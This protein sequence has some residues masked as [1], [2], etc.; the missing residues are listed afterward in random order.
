MKKWTVMLIP[1]DR[2]NTRT[3]TISSLHFWGVVGLLAV[4]TFTT[5]F[6]F[7]RHQV[8][9]SRVSTLREANRALELANSRKPQVV[10]QKGLSEEEARE[11]EQRL[12]AEYESS[13]STVTAQLNELLEIEAKARDITGMAP[14]DT[15]AKGQKNAAATGGKGGPAGPGGSFS[16][17][18]IREMLRPP[19][20]IYGMSRPSADLLLQEIQL[21]KHSLRDLVRDME[22]QADRIERMPSIWPLGRSAGRLISPYGYRRDP[23][24]RRIRLHEGTD[25]STNTGT[26]VRTTAKGVVRAAGYDGD[27]GYM[28][29]I[30]HGNGMSTC[31]A[32][33]SKITTKMGAEVSRGDVIGTVG[34]TGRSTGPH[35]HYEVRVNG[36]PVD[37]EKYLTD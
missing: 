21:R 27:Y 28:V 10:E 25:I 35:L 12:R 11:I 2:G 36:K 30:D 8:I 34:S 29:R 6:F 7:E 14:R 22:V 16:H 15:K 19:N 13:I 3:L 9:M 1:H 18:V 24:T 5:A 32:H 17:R 4:L 26:R 33:L 31:Y 37:P 23:F 20:V